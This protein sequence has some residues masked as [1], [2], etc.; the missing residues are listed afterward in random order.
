M[1]KFRL[2]VGLI[3][4]AGG[5]VL[6]GAMLRP[7]HMHSEGQPYHT[8]TFRMAYGGLPDTTNSLFTGSGKCAGCHGKDP[9]HF[10]SIAG[11]S[12]PLVPMPDGWDVNVTDHWRS[13]LMANSAKDPFWRAKVQHEVLVNPSHQLDLEDKCTS[14][15]APLGHFA[16]HHDGE[17]HYTM[18]ALLQ[19]SL[20]MDGVSCLACHQQSQ[21]AGNTFSGELTFDDSMA[22]GPYGAGKDEMP[23]YDLPMVTYTGYEPAYG[24]HIA[25]GE[26][27]AGCHSLVTQTT[28]LEGNYT[29]ADYV[30]Q[31]TY[32]EWLNSAYADDGEDPQTCNACHLP[33]IDDPVVISSGYVFLEPRAPYG[34]HY[35]VGGNAQ[36]LEIMRDNVDDL[37]LAATA[38]QFDSTLVQTR[39]M[40]REQTLEIEVVASDWIDEWGGSV[41]LKL[42]NKAGHKFPSGYPARRAWIEVKARVGNQTIWHSGAW[43]SENGSIIE[44]DEAGL[45]AYEPHHDV[46]SDESQVQIYEL[47]AADV[48]GSPTNLLERAAFSLK[49]NRLTPKGFS[50]DHAV[51][52]TT[53]VEG[54]AYEDESFD[55]ADGS[56]VI[57]YQFPPADAG[58]QVEVDVH[59]WYQAMPPRWINSM[60][61]FQDSTIQAFQTM[62]EAQG[63]APELV[64]DTT[65]VL[66]VAGSVQEDIAYERWSVYPNPSRDGRV[67]M[68]VPE[69]ARGALWE[70]YGM[71]GSR[72]ASGW[73]APGMEISLPKAQ[74]TYAIRWHLESGEMIS[75]KAVVRY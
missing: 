3:L 56:D 55:V 30:E 13:S 46:I 39:K 31:A 19:D 60:F 33:R 8:K 75:R 18:A 42:T 24:G 25:S 43:S 10:A 53:R 35:M 68:Q 72:M 66:D 1:N 32:H 69:R 52:D 16:A 29:G 65:F 73:T 21:D 15:H 28:D 57:T 45:S 48:T 54:L 22:Y 58:G 63:A 20:A 36:M 14:C 49:D 41:Q 62:F 6:T 59:V 74:G 2:L 17:P 34:L 37:G 7:N 51:Y 61:E 64:K 12:V 50:Y 4:A 11:Q 38:E 23:L 67:T 26:I 27:C 71:D 47:V 5:L 40:L 44:L 70:V 9:N